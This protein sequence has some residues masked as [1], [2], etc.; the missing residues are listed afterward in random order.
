VAGAAST[1]T[2]NVYD[3]DSARNF[4]I[5][6]NFTF[7]LGM[8]LRFA[9]VAQ[10]LQG[11]YLG[12]DANATAVRSR[13]SFDA[14]GP[15]ILA[16]GEWQFWR[17]FRVFGRGRGSLLMADFTNSLVETDNDGAT[18]NANLIETYLMTVPVLELASGVAW[19]RRNVR[20]AVGYEIQNWFNVID[21]PTFVDDFAEGKIGR[22]QSDLGIEGLFF[23]LGLAF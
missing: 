9:D 10:T 16:Q 8:G 2:M 21:S 3:F 20:V 4:Q 18:T 5:D 1:L 17:E 6:D 23:Q 7:R 22:R 14:T 11:F 19:Q 15:T 13:V 12:G